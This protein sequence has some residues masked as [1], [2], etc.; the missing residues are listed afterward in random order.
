[1]QESSRAKVNQVMELA[2]KLQLKV[3]AKTKMENSGFLENVV[4][5]IDEEQYQPAA[6]VKDTP[7]AFGKPSVPQTSPEEAKVTPEAPELTSGGAEVIPA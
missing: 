4:I 5:W 7:G 2:K 3:E 1:M 6:I